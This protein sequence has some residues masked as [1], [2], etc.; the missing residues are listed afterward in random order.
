M[1]RL[2]A[3]SLP[4]REKS[5]GKCPEKQEWPWVFGE[6]NEVTGVGGSGQVHRASLTSGGWGEQK[7]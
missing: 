4:G 2:G 7:M 3:Q 6:L 5:T 1:R